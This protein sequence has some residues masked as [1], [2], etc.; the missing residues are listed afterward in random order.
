MSGADKLARKK[1]E[2]RKEEILQI[3]IRIFAEN[4]FYKAT[5]ALI[6]KEA[7]VTQPYLFHF[8]KSKEELFLAVLDKG[9]SIIHDAF[10]KVEG[11]GHQI[12]EQMGMAFQTLMETN[13]DELLLTMFAFVTPEPAI[14]IFAHDNHMK[15]YLMIREKFEKA[16]IENAAIEAKQFIGIG[17][18]ISMA[19]ILN[20]PRLSH[21][22]Q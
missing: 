5:T 19:E 15:I 6:A 12:M 4:G 14:R 9:T 22:N 2:D 8:Y 3:A 18:M 11:E 1:L 20:E 13:R 7:G 21:D 16:G 10:L 17:L